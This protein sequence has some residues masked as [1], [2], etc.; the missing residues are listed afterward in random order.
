MHGGHMNTMSQKQPDEKCKTRKMLDELVLREPKNELAWLQ[1]SELV[2]HQNEAIDCLQH[3]L[4]INPGNTT[5]KARLEQLLLAEKKT[6]HNTK[7]AV[8]DNRRVSYKS[9]RLGATGS[10]VSNMFLSVILDLVI[11]LIL[12]ILFPSS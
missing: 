8:N 2:E 10:V 4:T 3:A 1:L 6:Q 7:Q 9:P 11:S 12:S 5:V